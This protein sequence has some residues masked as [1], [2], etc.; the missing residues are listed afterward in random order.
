MKALTL[1]QPWASL[2][3]IE[4][5]TVET[6]SWKTSYRGPLAIHAAKGW[7]LDA[8]SISYEPPF[9]DTLKAAGLDPF[10]PTSLPRGRVIATCELVDIVPTEHCFSQPEPPFRARYQKGDKIYLPPEE[11]AFGDYSAGRFAWLL[12]NIRALAY[13]VPARGYQSLWEWEG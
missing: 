2:V 6:R 8:Q 7:P 13:P 10:A 3:A 11:W 9:L 1:T 5:K 12:D 4:A